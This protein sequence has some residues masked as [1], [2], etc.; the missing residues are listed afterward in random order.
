MR[1]LLAATLLTSLV[2]C[3]EPVE[4]PPVVDAAAPGPDAA[5]AS[6][7]EDTAALCQ[8][9]LDNDRDGDSDC[10]DP[11]C[12]LFVFCLRAD[13]GS[14]PR[15]DAGTPVQDSGLFGDATLPEG[16]TGTQ[17]PADASVPAADTGT[18]QP[19]DASVAPD[20]A[21]PGPDA[22]MPAECNAPRALDFGA[23]PVGVK[24]TKPLALRNT[25]PQPWSVTVGNLSGPDVA[26]FSLT[27]LQ[28]GLYTV[29]P[30]E[31]LSLLVSVTAPRL[32]ALAAQLSFGV[33]N[34]CALA[35]LPITA[36]GVDA[37]LECFPRIKVGN[38][39]ACQLDFGYVAPG[40]AREG[41]VTF[42]NHGDQDVTVG[43]FA[44]TQDPK[45]PSFVQKGPVANLLVPKNSGSARL[46][47]GF[48]P[49][50]MG[51]FSGKLAFTSTDVATPSGQVA[52]RG[53][54]AGPLLDA[55]PVVDL[56]IVP[57]GGTLTA[58]V[59]LKNVG[60]DI[61]GETD[62]NLQ[63]LSPDPAGTICAVAAD[64][65]SARCIAGACW[66]TKPPELLN[67][68]PEFTL[69]WPSPGFPAAGLPAGQTGRV[70]VKLAPTSAG[71]K[72][73]TLRL[74]TNDPGAQAMDVQLTASAQVMP[75]CAYVVEPPQLAFG[76]VE[77][78][79][80]VT[81]AS[82][83]RNT[84]ADSC[85]VTLSLA[86]GTDPAFTLV[87]GPQSQALP[88]GQSLVVPVRFAPVA[89]GTPAGQLDVR[90]SSLTAPQALVPLTGRAAITC[91]TVVPDRLD[92]GPTQQ[93][94]KAA[95]RTLT[96]SND[97]S[98]AL[99]VSNITLQTT[100]SDLRLPV[101]PTLP[102][103]LAGF[104][105]ST[106]RV[107]Y[108]PG[109]L[110]ADVGALQVNTSAATDPVLIPLQ[111]EGVAATQ[112]TETWV[113]P[114]KVDVLFV[115]D[116]S[117]SMSDKQT[118]LGTA[119]AGFINYATS[120]ALDYRIAVTT[121]GVDIEH[122]NVV[123]NTPD[124]RNGCLF[125][126]P[127]NPKVLTPTTPNGATVFAQNVQV[128]T[129]G[130]YTE[131]LIRPA[132]LTFGPEAQAG[133]SAGF[134]RPDAA[135][136]VVVVSDASDQDLFP[137]EAYQAHF[138]S[139]RP[140]NTFAFHAVI[141]HKPVPGGCYTDDPD[142]NTRVEELVAAT[143]GTTV[144][145]CST[146]WTAAMGQLGKAVFGYRT[147]YR[148]GSVPVAGSVTVTVNGVA[149]PSSIPGT[150]Y[151]LYDAAANAVDFTAAGLPPVTSQ[152]LIGYQAACL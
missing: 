122:G 89:A 76:L 17:P 141:P 136:S 57:V 138:L 30:G 23:V 137:L 142:G 140:G 49:G 56:G 126:A 43:A 78:G 139:L 24:A 64:C 120:Q 11:D 37:T 109:D 128:G 20:A 44:L 150:T 86:P 69:T 32:G 19:S 117:G 63:L 27:G 2:A 39:W 84:G 77:P 7:P 106:V 21:A 98:T 13:T 10:D 16:D 58:Q 124:D 46:T 149:L 3:S 42:V 90:T 131:M 82:V 72:T 18:A 47:L 135:L 62:D 87:N 9:G 146:D 144:D 134:P 15:P 75:P 79:R 48:Q 123:S 107:A 111:G 152:V 132:F 50:V 61:A 54:G 148:L 102:L 104:S 145:I 116:D 127:G 36:R 129:S 59:P 110:G 113:R 81:L 93:G 91:L 45:G 5:A 60:T 52:L 1:R 25:S 115:V 74:Y 125:A 40:E 94:C 80:V 151:W 118:A 108:Q 85:Q 41:A 6:I 73:A 121:T 53:V 130:N 38:Q 103:T 29:N 114:T 22:S 88:A 133:C 83:V 4:I 70:E 112:R 97:C 55:A 71:T 67:A 92:F 66:S 12:Q 51:L 14:P 28:P 100:G 31:T 8:D 95:E 35:T 65:A 96:L 147:R 34:A 105:R 119:F 33:P 26:A 68:S 101:A 99:L 143:G